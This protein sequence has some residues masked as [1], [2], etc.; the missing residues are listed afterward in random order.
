[1]AEGVGRVAVRLPS[2]ILSIGIGI[3]HL[4][5]RVARLAD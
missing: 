2:T 4:F 1:V 3:T 5:L